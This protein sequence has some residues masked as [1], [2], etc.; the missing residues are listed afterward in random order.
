MHDINL[1]EEM[2]NAQIEFEQDN[3]VLEVQ[4]LLSQESSNEK[5]IA[6]RIK[7]G[8]FKDSKRPDWIKDLDPCRRFNTESI[9]KIC[10]KFRLRFLKSE[11]F[12]GEIPSE[13]IREVKRIES[14]L[15][16]SFS[17]FKII[18]PEERFN[19]KDSTK[20]PILMAE[21]PNGQYY[22]IFQWGDDM[23]WYQEILKFPFRHI[24]ALAASSSTIGLLIAFLVPS[25]FEAVQAEFFFRF[26]MFSMTTCLLMTLAIIT[27]IMHSKDFSENVWNSKFIK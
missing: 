19:L 14:T 3:L 15:G 4:S 26:F 1:F 23:K 5:N 18:A 11:L 8:A 9:E 7:K 21:L 17:S 22:F 13:A 25:Q 2:A 12:K 27:A 16:V 10:T 24:G 20:D 6:S